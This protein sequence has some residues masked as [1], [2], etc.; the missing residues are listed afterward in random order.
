ML[1]SQFNCH[2]VTV[3]L[4]AKH[5]L[6]CLHSNFRN[7]ELKVDIK[8]QALKLRETGNG[9]LKGKGTKKQ[10]QIKLRLIKS[11]NQGMLTERTLG[12]ETLRKIVVAWATRSRHLS[13]FE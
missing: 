13:Y 9:E 6:D 8:N 2:L 4:T 3:K 11:N 1:T 7:G 12:Q 5:T 10:I